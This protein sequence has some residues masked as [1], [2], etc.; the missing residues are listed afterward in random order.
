MNKKDH[1]ERLKR[2]AE[3]KAQQQQRSIEKIRQRMPLT[4]LGAER[5]SCGEC[6]ACCTVIGIQGDKNCPPSGVYEACTH[7]CEKGCGIYSYRPEECRTY[8]CL[9]QRGLLTKDEHRPD[10]LGI[11]IDKRRS[12]VG[13]KG[14]APRDVLVLWEVRAGAFDEPAVVDL[15][16]WLGRNIVD[17]HLVFNRFQAVEVG[18]DGLQ[19]IRLL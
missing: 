14:S 18:E 11:L 12:G 6:Q 1:R 2:K 17:C 19:R 7:L 3:W 13:D 10:R 15:I 16:A 8:E 9:W 4:L 5:R